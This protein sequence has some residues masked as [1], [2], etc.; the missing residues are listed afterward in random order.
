MGNLSFHRIAYAPGE[1]I[2]S[3]EEEQSTAMTVIQGK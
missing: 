1:L 3:P 2:V